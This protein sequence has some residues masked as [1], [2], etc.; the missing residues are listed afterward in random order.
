M[1]QSE[2]KPID[3]QNAWRTLTATEAINVA[4]SSLGKCEISDAKY[5]AGA[6]SVRKSSPE[7]TVGSARVK[8]NQRFHKSE[9]GIVDVN[10]EVIVELVG[11]ADRE[12][13]TIEVK[14]SVV[15][16][17]SFAPDLDDHVMIVAAKLNGA[18][19][20]WPLHR[21]F[22]LSSLARMG[23]ATFTL[24]LMMPYQAALQAGFVDDRP[25]ETQ[26]AVESANQ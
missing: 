7:E 2:S 15:T 25:P 14:A 8:T 23:I 17:Y 19:H 18:M 5:I 11:E 10:T 13:V 16:K 6:F 21:E 26:G 24:P 20:S 1:S 12:P 3:P 22:V 9:G 4:A